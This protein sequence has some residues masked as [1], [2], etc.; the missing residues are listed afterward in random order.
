MHYFNVV[1][2]HLSSN[3]IDLNFFFF[4]DDA[5]MTF[6]NRRCIVTGVTL[7]NL[8]RVETKFNTNV[9]VYKLVETLEEATTAELVRR[10][11]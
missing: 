2:R 4:G 6:S 3:S 7:D 11:F 8:Y 10:S 9:C 1:P 5:T